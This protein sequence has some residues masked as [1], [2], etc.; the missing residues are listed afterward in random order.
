MNIKKN[1]Q[2]NTR[3]SIITGH[4][5]AGKTNFAVNYALWL[6]NQGKSVTIA[7][8]DIVNPYFRTADFGQL[9]AD[10]GITLAVSDFANSSLDIPSVRLNVQGALGESDRL[11]IDVGGDADGAK[12]LGR[13]NE[14]IADFKYEMLYVVNCYRC[15]TQTATEAVTLMRSIE[16]ASGL[17]CTAIVNN[18]NLGRETTAQIVAESLPFADEVS[19]LTGLPL[20]EIPIQVYVKAFWNK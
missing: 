9:F 7:D 10:S 19:E 18:S 20:F 2:N 15:L 13:F 4:F 11:I 14:I 3:I 6:K 1:N 12:A 8:L 5:G 17:K 16:S